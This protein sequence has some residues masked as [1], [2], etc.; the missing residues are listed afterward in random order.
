MF[1]TVPHSNQRQKGVSPVVQDGPD[2]RSLSCPP[3]PRR[4]L[5]RQSDS[6]SSEGETV[7]GAKRE[8]EEQT[9]HTWGVSPLPG[10]GSW[11]PG[12]AATIAVGGGAGG[13][14]LISRGGR[15]GRA[16]SSDPEG[17][18]LNES[19]VR[20]APPGWRRT[21]TDSQVSHT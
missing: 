5:R 17:G 19:L 14:P 18:E 4:C 9:V 13:L 11:C 20:G 1:G 2:R 15:R 6:R 8:R 3:P 16:Q 21:G 12:A 7:N 10:G